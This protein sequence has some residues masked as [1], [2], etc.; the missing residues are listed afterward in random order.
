MKLSPCGCGPQHYERVQRR[1]WM[2]WFEGRRYYHCTNCKANMF[3][4]RED[5][6]VGPAPLA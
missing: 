1:W 6:R 4:R 5:A 3:L 2:R